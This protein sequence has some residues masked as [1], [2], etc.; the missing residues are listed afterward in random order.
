MV[1]GAAELGA[2]GG[3][4][5]ALAEAAGAGTL[6]YVAALWRALFVLK[7]DEF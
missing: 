2:V 4:V 1:L 3:A 6:G 5:V 7:S